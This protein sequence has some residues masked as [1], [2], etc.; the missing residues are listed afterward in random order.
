MSIKS[1]HSKELEGEIGRT[2]E[3]TFPKELIDATEAIV[4]EILKMEELPYTIDTLRAML[5]GI[6]YLQSIHTGVQEA[7]DVDVHKSVHA[8]GSIMVLIERLRNEEAK[9]I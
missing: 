9:K 8:I 7:M 6:K 2:A 4:R 3:T 1:Q 5:Y